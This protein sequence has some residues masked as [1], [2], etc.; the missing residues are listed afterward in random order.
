MEICTCRSCGKTQAFI[1]QR[2][3]AAFRESELPP[4]PVGPILIPET[5]REVLDDYCKSLGGTRP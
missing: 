2:K 4:W 5:I 3:G 1:T